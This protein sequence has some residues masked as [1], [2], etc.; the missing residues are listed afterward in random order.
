MNPMN[1][2]SQSPINTTQS[3]IDKVSLLVSPRWAEYLA[4]MLNVSADCSNGA[5]LPTGMMTM[6]A[7]F[8]T[9]KKTTKTAEG[10]IQA[11]YVLYNDVS[12]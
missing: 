7:A 6:T 4:Y 5:I 9:K 10:S 11:F 8:E 1:K 2:S 3:T 12:V